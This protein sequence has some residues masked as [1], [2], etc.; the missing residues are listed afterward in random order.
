M[1]GPG[2]FGMLWRIEGVL[3]AV[4][5]ELAHLD[6]GDASDGLRRAA[7]IEARCREGLEGVLPLS[8]TPELDRLLSW[9]DRGLRTDGELRVALAQLDGWLSGLL[10]G[11]GYAVG[12]ASSDD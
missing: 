2:T 7:T 3:T 4:R 1:V 11:I 10:S 5:G 8:L 9:S 12:A 6:D